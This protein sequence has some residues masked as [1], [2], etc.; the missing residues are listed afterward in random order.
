MTNPLYKK[1]A[2]KMA[3]K[4]ASITFILT[5]FSFD[6]YVFWLLRD[7]NMALKNE[8]TGL[9]SFAS[10][11]QTNLNKTRVE[12]TL[13][14]NALQDEKQINL[15]FQDQIQGIIG[16]VSVLEKL[17]KT[18]TELL[19]KYSKIYFLNENY[20]PERLVVID[21]SYLLEQSR[22]LLMHEKVWPYLKTLLDN[23]QNE[24][25]TIQIASAY[26]SFG[27][28]AG[29]KSANK[30]TYGAGTANKFSAD[31]GYS[32]HQLGTT[33]DFTTSKIGATLSGFDKTEAYTWLLGN[34]Y[35]Y[36][37]VISYPK[38]NKY[39]IFE[40]WHWRFVGVVLATKIHDQS[41][42]FYALDQRDINQYLV[43]IF[44]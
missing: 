22:S 40:S 16:T 17:S 44:D 23:A 10:Q 9:E 41:T 1:E 37:F 19:K 12:K 36:G 35:K 38:E 18:D 26:R 24:G 6:G 20:I 39:Y 29:I 32:E 4:I 7:E 21:K 42:Y 5:S 30:V 14:E 2:T 8:L 31:Q 28:Q 27:D 13:L 3:V 34:A 15:S 43:N 25:V 33:L 11:T